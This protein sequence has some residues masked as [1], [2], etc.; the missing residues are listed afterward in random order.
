MLGAFEPHLE[1]VD[2][3]LT[4]HEHCRSS[5]IRRALFRIERTV[6]H[7]VSF[8]CIPLQFLVGYERVHPNH[9]GTVLALPKKTAD[10]I[11]VYESPPAP[12]HVVNGAAGAMQVEKW[13]KPSPPWSAVRYADG[14]EN[15]VEDDGGSSNAKAAAMWNYENSFGFGKISVQGATKLVF[16]FVPIRDESPLKD[17]F[18][19][20]KEKK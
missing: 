17:T 13:H 4:G 18:V 11:D 16:E 10:G 9:N 15:T 14:V 3:V 19:I 8:L 2:L 12:V 1:H 5:T 7:S 6:F 20:T